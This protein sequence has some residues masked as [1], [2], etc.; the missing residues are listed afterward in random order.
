MSG[1]YY[2]V[3]PG[4]RPPV[5]HVPKFLWGEYCDYDSDGNSR[6]PDSTDWTE[7]DIALRPFRR[8][9]VGIGPIKAPKL[10]LRIRANSPELARR[11]AS[12]L[13]NIAGGELK[14]T[15]P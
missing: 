15:W 7:L 11:C 13:Q 6:R 1:D 10:V 3:S 8:E 14:G 2:L 4:P 9:W 12:F 5:D